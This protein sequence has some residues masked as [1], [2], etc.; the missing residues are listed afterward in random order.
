MKTE[1]EKREEKLLEL[2]NAAKPLLELINSKYH[3][4]VTI[5]ITSDTVEVLEGVIA[6]QNH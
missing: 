3:P 6:Y 1:L 4:H 5:I 2:K